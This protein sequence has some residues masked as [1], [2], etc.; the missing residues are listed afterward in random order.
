MPKPDITH[1]VITGQPAMSKLCIIPQIK[2]HKPNILNL[3]R[4]RWWCY[5]GQIFHS[6]SVHLKDT[7]NHVQ[8]VDDLNET[9]ET[10]SHSKLVVTLN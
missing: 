10:G 1:K 8:H 7:Q 6:L 5:Y 4:G 2:G 3:F 9:T